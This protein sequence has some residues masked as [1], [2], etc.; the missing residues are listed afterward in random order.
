MTEEAFFMTNRHEN[1]MAGFLPAALPDRVI[2]DS[3]ARFTGQEYI[4]VNEG[5]VL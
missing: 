4:L 1:D 3:T 2:L 5:L